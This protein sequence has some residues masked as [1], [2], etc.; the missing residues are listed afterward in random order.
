MKKFLLIQASMSLLLVSLSCGPE[1]KIEE[2]AYKIGDTGPGEGIVFYDKGNNSGGW[3]YL[4]VSTEEQAYIRKWGCTGKTIKDARGTK[5]GTGRENTLAIIKNCD[6]PI[7]AANLATT[8]TGGEKDDWYLP[9]IDELKLINENL[10]TR[11]MG[12]ID[13][14]CAYWSSTEIDKDHAAG[15]QFKKDGKGGVVTLK[16][17][18]GE[19]DP[20]AQVRAV[21]RF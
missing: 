6:Q 2:A 21:R 18:S 12:N 1:I 15:F 9:S 7:I 5:P 19:D 16:K 14:N 10:F 13:M 3:R 4:E 17:D 11:G 20:C 8:C